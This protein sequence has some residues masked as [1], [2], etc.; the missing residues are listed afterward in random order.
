MKPLL[1]F[2]M[3]L[4]LAVAASIWGPALSANDGCGLQPLKPLPPLGCRDLVAVCVCDSGGENC[5]WEWR[6]VR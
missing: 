3:F 2:A 5:R 4:L 6:C 1:L